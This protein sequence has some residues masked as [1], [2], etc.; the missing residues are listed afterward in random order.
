[1][2]TIPELLDLIENE[3]AALNLPE[4]PANLY[5]PIRYILEKGGKRLRPLLVLSA[6]SMFDDDV[7]KALKPAVG[8]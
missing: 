3:I 5:E 7:E 1:M 2:K 4:V 6:F 8:L